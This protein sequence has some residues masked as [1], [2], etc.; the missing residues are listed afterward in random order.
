[1]RPIQRWLDLNGWQASISPCFYSMSP[2][3]HRPTSAPFPVIPCVASRG[4]LQWSNRDGA[5]CRL[6]RMSVS[7]H[8]ANSIRIQQSFHQSSLQTAVAVCMLLSTKWQRLGNVYQHD[9]SWNQMFSFLI[10]QVHA[11]SISAIDSN[12]WLGSDWWNSFYSVRDSPTAFGETGWT[13]RRICQLSGGAFREKKITRNRKENNL[14]N[15][16]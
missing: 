11:G 7:S 15:L 3:L 16:D 1:M 8:P 10:S 5:T 6:P 14:C 12:E 2:L 4:T 13:P 9:H